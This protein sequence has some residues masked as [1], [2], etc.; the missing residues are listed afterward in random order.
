MDKPHTTH[1]LL[2]SLL[3]QA[4]VELPR[5]FNVENMEIGEFV[6][7]YV[8]T[9]SAVDL[10]TRS[11]IR[12]DTV[13]REVS[14]LLAEYPDETIAVL[15]ACCGFGSLAKRLVLSVPDVNRIA[16]WAVDQER[17]YIHSILA[18]EDAFSVLRVSL[19]E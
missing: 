7:R 17:Q 4:G 9:P 12:E 16:F 2:T 14:R 6:N 11:S 5:Q 18:E 13:I 10:D 3:L 1:S 15:D 8:A 19:P